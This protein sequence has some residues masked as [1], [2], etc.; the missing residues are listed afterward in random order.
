MGMTTARTYYVVFAG[1]TLGMFFVA[2]VYP[3]FLA[4]R[5]L[6][7][8]EVNA[9]LAVYLVTTFL[10]EVP[11]GVVADRFGRKTSFVLACALRAVAFA[12]YARAADF[13]DCVGAE[14]IDAIG[15]TLASGAL[16]AWLVDGLHA[17]GDTRPTDGLFARAQVV[18]RAVMVVGAVACGYLAAVG[19][20]LPWIAGAAIFAATGLVGAL[21]MREPPRVRHATATPPSLAGIARDAAAAVAA[22]PVLLLICAL[23]SLT[24]FAALPLH[25]V[26]QAHLQDVAGASLPALGWATAALHVAAL[27]GSALVP[28]ALRRVRRE[29]ALAVAALW[30][31]AMVA[32][33]AR[34]TTLAPALAGLLLQEASWALSEPV[35]AAWTNEHV[36]SARRATVLSVRSLFFTLGGAV[37]LVATGL[38]ARRTG[39]PAVLLVSALVFAATAPLFRVL[40]RVA[41]TA[42]LPELPAA[43]AAVGAT[44][45][46]PDVAP[47]QSSGR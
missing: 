26:W 28:L 45:V 31:A 37:G 15:T 6:D 46:A 12:L 40:G 25:M 5:G 14:V 33:L 38:L 20:A 22:S 4:S 10:F 32:V 18:A 11:T 23:F 3:L 30:R 19:W 29:T 34:A 21:A 7:L 1:Y 41:R 44:K 13:A 35:Y 27:G 17:E 47:A 8:F 2:P 36:A 43:L 42:A 9:V 24:A 16:E 39:I